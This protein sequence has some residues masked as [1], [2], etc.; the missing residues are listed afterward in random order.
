MKVSLRTL[1]PAITLGAVTLATC[2]TLLTC[3]R[4][5]GSD[6]L[7]AAKQ[8]CTENNKTVEEFDEIKHAGGRDKKMSKLDSIAYSDI[9]KTTKLAQDSTKVAEFNK[10]AAKNRSL[11]TYEDEPF[12]Y[13]FAIRSFLNDK[14]TKYGMHFKDYEKMQEKDDV[15][16]RQNYIDNFVYQKFF[17]DNNVLDKKVK[18]L[19]DAYSKRISSNL[20]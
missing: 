5:S 14:A 2:N 17:K 10:I 7:S 8:Y 16:Y 6:V 18:A 19:C 9:F 4:N 1:V 3:N 13:N 12:F 11:T 20:K 15:A